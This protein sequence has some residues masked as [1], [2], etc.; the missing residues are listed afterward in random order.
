MVLKPKSIF[1]TSM[2]FALGA[3]LLVGCGE[4]TGEIT[5][6]PLLNDTAPKP[7]VYNVDLDGQKISIPSPI[8]TAFLLQ[9]SGALYNESYTNAAN[10]YSLYSTKFKKGLNLGIYGADLG[11]VTIYDNSAAAMEYMGSV[12]SLANDL[13]VAGAF[14]AEML[15]RFSDNMGNE[16]SMLVLVSESFRKGD[17]YLKNNDRSEIAS[18]ILAGGWIEALYFASNVALESN[19][20]EVVTRIGDQKNTLT[21]LRM[22]IGQYRNNGEDYDELYNNL[23]DLEDAF[24]EIEFVYKYEKPISHPERKLTVIN[25]KS[26]VKVTPEQLKDISDKIIALRNQIVG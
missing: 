13:D 6:Q 9:K 15:Q 17:E 12:Q 10:N 5:D 26:E 11:Y 7:E 22:L 24:A 14:D 20:E 1:K 2:L 16:D 21:N 25:C 8:Q 23:L 18:L 4:P 19:N 3:F